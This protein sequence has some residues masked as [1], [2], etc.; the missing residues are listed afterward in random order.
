M[1]KGA[2]LVDM[3]SSLVGEDLH[4]SLSNLTQHSHSPCTLYSNPIKELSLMKLVTVIGTHPS[5]RNVLTKTG[6][7][8][9]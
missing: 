3:T 7:T 8:E 4:G 9:V 2:L 5:K 6:A 1:D